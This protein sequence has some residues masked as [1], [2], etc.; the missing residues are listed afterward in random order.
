MKSKLL[1]LA[2]AAMVFASFS[3][4]PATIRYVNINS[5]NPISPYTDW[6][7][8]ATNIQDA[9]D[10]ALAGDE[11]LVTN[12]VCRTGGAGINFRR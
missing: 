4:A 5:T 10:A 8:A 6:S 11:V 3:S 7:T 1:R 12:G 2:T 9:V